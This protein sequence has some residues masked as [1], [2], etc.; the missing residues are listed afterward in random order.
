MTWIEKPEDVTDKIMDQFE[1]AL[2]DAAE[3]NSI[4]AEWLIKWYAL[5]SDQ[6]RRQFIVK[7]AALTRKV[8]EAV[9]NFY[10]R[11]LGAWFGNAA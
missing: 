7:R 3:T 8:L 4:A 2:I 5:K 10:D 6:E 1:K 11:L 9:R